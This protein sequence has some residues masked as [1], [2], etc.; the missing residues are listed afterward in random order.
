MR[1][2]DLLTPGEYER[3][4]SGLPVSADPDDADILDFP[5]QYKWLGEQLRKHGAE[6][7]TQGLIY[8]RISYCPD[9]GS[10]MPEIGWKVQENGRMVR[11]TFYL[12]EFELSE[13]QIL[14]FDDAMWV[15]ALNNSPIAAFEAEEELLASPEAKVESWARMFDMGFP[16]PDSEYCDPDY[17]DS[18]DKKY[19]CGA[20]WQLSKDKVLRSSK[21]HGKVKNP[22]K[23][24]YGKIH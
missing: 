23:V 1:L 12:V 11:K 19:L 7:E 20:Y 24:L 15:C 18:F 5:F 22:D 14:V 4:N 9:L 2:F 3:L 13:D 17:W 8:P 16:E 10:G 6:P 21:H